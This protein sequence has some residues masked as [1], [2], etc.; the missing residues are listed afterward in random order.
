LEKLDE[1]I[2]EIGN[3]REI[4][5]AL[6]FNSRTGRKI[7]NQVVGPFGEEITN[8]NGDK[9]NDVCE[10]NSLKILN[11]YFK[12]KRIHQYTWHQDTLELKS[13]IDY[14]IARQN[15]GLKFQDV[16]VF[17]RMTVGSDHYLVNAKILFLYG[18]TLT[19]E[20]REII[21]DGVSEIS[22]SPLHNIDSL[23]DESTSFFIQEEIR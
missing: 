6:D 8:D 12:H 4:L 3:F 22:Q 17:R 16:R 7:N 14:I 21:T 23:R 13:I 9:L 11:G 2:A 10:Q 1:V 20:S 15:S 18:K 5:I 19:T